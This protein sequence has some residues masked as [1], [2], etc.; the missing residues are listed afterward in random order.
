M[1][2]SEKIYDL[3]V[4]R[5]GVWLLNK[6][7]RKAG[8]LVLVKALLSPLIW[9]HD[10]F[11]RYRKAKLYQLMISSQVCY[12]ERLLNDRYDFTA[13]RIY[14]DDAIWHQA[15]YLYQD[16]ELKPEWLYQEGE[17]NP[18]W[19][20]SENE[21]GELKDDFVVFVPAAMDFDENEMRSLLDNY[22]LFGT[23]YKIERV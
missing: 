13:R 9:L 15:W 4:D 10:Y 14:I 6:V 17:N 21:A 2:V 3:N 23:H 8:I 16:E 5:L 12:L 22:R 11:I 7:N 1:A 18:V 20:Y 19:L